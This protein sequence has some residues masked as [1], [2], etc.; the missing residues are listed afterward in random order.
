MHY[1]IFLNI[2]YRHVNSFSMKK[3]ILLILVF[4]LSF[5]QAFAEQFNGNYIKVFSDSDKCD[6]IGDA[7]LNINYKTAK[8][9]IKKWR[10]LDTNQFKQKLFK[11]KIRKNNTDIFMQA[12]AIGYKHILKGTIKDDKIFLT[13]SSTHTEMNEKLGGCSFEFLRN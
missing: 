4:L 12:R 9:K 8:I 2:I 6:I 5:S 7:V 1:I 11:G 10:W 3:V 13:F